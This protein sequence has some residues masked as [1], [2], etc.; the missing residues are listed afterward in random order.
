MFKVYSSINTYIPLKL[1]IFDILPDTG[2][3][4]ESAVE[5]LTQY[6]TPRGNRD[7]A[8][9]EFR[10]L[11]QETNE[12]ITEYYRRLKTKAADCEFE[13]EDEEIKIQIIHKTRDQ[14]LRK[15]ALRESLD[16][17]SLLAHG[18]SLEITDEQAQRLENASTELNSLKKNR[19]PSTS[20]PQGA[21]NRRRKPALLDKKK[22]V[23]KRGGAGEHFHTKTGCKIALLEKN[24]AIIAENSDISPNYANPTVSR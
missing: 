5:S 15:R 3:T 22:N 2:T 11:I 4:Y 10:G 20:K 14:R 17:K 7:V 23:Q 1:T 12:T 6:F 8:I 16:L 18:N 13:N 24:L 9:F 21:L 19:Q